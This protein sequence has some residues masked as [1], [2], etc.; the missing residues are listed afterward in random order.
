MQVFVSWLISTLLFFVLAALMV[1]ILS[2]RKNI[3]RRICIWLAVFSL[4]VG[5]TFHSLSYITQYPSPTYIPIAMLNG[6]F[7]AIM[8]FLFPP[9][10]DGVFEFIAET[11][12]LANN[13]L[14]LII[15]WISQVTV[16]IAVQTFVIYLVGKKLLDSIRIRIGGQKEIYIILG[17]EKDAVTLGENIATRDNPSATPLANRL[18]L[19]LIDESINEKEMY[20]KVMHFGGIVRTVDRNHDLEYF[21]NS[22]GLGKRY[23]KIQ[24]KKYKVFLM[25]GDMYAA[26]K[27]LRI[28]N[29]TAKNDKD[30]KKLHL[31]DIY[32]LTSSNWIKENVIEIINEEKI[33]YTFH[34]IDETD[35]FVRKMIT[36]HPPVECPGLEIGKNTPGKSTREFNV[37]I[38]GFDTVGQRALV[39]LIMNGQFVRENNNDGKGEV[40]PVMRAII[41]DN[42]ADRQLNCFRNDIPALDLCC[43]IESENMTVPCDGLSGYLDRELDYIVIALGDDCANRFTGRYIYNYYKNKGK[44]KEKIPYIAVYEKG[45]I[46]HKAK[47]GERIFCFGCRD[48]IY[49][50]NVIIREEY[51]NRA[52]AVSGIYDGITDKDNLEK[53]WRAFNLFTL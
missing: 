18:I 7:S 12:W 52:K 39:H 16:R 14:L 50:D 28:A 19:F 46:P 3:V 32:V 20:E 27:A 31:L 13:T 44:A 23:E 11:D 41:L 10:V 53:K 26:D 6:L 17:G 51:D 15:Y 33:K 42:E 21:L 8:M 36:N 43:E 2:H 30:N 4:I 29:F 38:L 5:F 48:E 22:T 24:K 45:G 37:M 25:P 47:A 9:G 40:K 1:Y 35:L 34:I 49:T